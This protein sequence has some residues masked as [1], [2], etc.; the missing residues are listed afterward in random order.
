MD[1]SQA[2]ERFNLEKTLN[3]LIDLDF[4]ELINNLQKEILSSESI[5]IPSKAQYKRDIEYLQVKY[6]S[7]LKGFAFILGQGMKPA[8]VDNDTIQKFRPI[9]EELIKKGQLKESILKVIE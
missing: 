4:I 9:I 2:S 1:Y 3:R 6:I 5:K 7:N 8:G